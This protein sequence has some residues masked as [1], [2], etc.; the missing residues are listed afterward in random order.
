VQQQ[1]QTA[2]TNNIQ[3]MNTNNLTSFNQNTSN[4]NNNNNNQQQ[5]QTVSLSQIN[6]ASLTNNGGVQLQT[7]NANRNANANNAQVFIYFICFILMHSTMKCIMIISM[8]VH[9]VII[10]FFSGTYA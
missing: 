9:G 5:Q 3:T 10:L 7:L 2:Q 6:F 1:Q 8:R 4:N